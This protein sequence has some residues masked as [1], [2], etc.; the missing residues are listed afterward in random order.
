MSW[1]ITQVGEEVVDG[2]RDR[3]ALFCLDLP[4][5][6]SHYDCGYD[7]FLADPTDLT[8]KIDIPVIEANIS[9]DNCSFGRQ[10]HEYC[11]AP[12]NPKYCP[13]GQ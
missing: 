12:E 7:D 4:F 10:W 1:N 2:T 6:L 3:R 13:F 11:R 8:G 5:V 9:Y